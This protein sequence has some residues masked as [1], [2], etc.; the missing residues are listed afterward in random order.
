MIPL[1]L[2]RIQLFAPYP[3]IREGEGLNPDVLLYMCDNT[4][5][6]QAMRNRLFLKW[7]N[8]YE[9]KRKY[10]LLNEMILDEGV[11]NYVSC[12]IS[13][14]HPRFDE[15]VNYFNEVISLFKANKP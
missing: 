1:D 8:T 4:N 15:V 2:Q 13:L 12:I 5:D 9:M 3:V 10:F 11:E 14:S 6:Q 7:F